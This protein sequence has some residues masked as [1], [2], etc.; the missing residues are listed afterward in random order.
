MGVW[1]AIAK[2]IV[3]IW[4]GLNAIDDL[5]LLFRF[6]RLGSVLVP[7]LSSLQPHMMCDVCDDVMGDLLKGSDGLEALPCGAAC[8]RIPACVRMCENLKNAATNSSHFPCIAAGYCDAVEEGE[9]DA[10]VECRVGAFF[11][12]APRRYCHRSRHGLRFS[13]SLRPGIGRWVGMRNAVASH[14]GALAEGLLS[15][16]RC[17]EPGAG[18]WC[19]ARPRGTGA[20]AEALGHALALLYGG[21]E[22]V[23]SI[24][25]P[26]GDDD[27]QWLIFWLALTLLLFVERFLARVLLSTVPMYYEVK[28]CLLVW[29]ARGGGADT[30]YRRL[31]R[32]LLD[33]LP[34]QLSARVVA[35]EAGEAAK[36]LARLRRDVGGVVGLALAA[37]EKRKA[38]EKAAAEERRRTPSGHVRPPDWEEEEED[39]EDAACAEL[40]AVYEFML[41]EEGTHALAQAP[42]LDSARAVDASERALLIERAAALVSFQPRFVVARLLPVDDSD[43]GTALPPMDPNGLVDAY[44]VLRLEPPGGGGARS[45]YPARGVRSRVAYRTLRPNWGETLELPLRGGHMDDD[46]MYHNQVE[47]KATTLHV[48]VCDADMGAW[49]WLLLLAEFA[50]VALALGALGAHITGALDELTAAHRRLATRATTAIAGVLVVSFV[51]SKRFHADDEVIGEA[52]VP[53]S[54]LLDQRAHT[55]QFTLRTPQFSSVASEVGFSPKAS[56]QAALARLWGHGGDSAPPPAEPTRQRRA[57]LTRST[58]NDKGEVLNSA[59][60][61]KRNEVGGLGVIRM[62]LACSER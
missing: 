34:R 54:T 32:F 60:Q 57:T 39:R 20:V 7:G 5:S 46:G 14:A 55:I 3:V 47:P 19:V 48:E 15:Q 53:V 16:P 43:P 37:H 52:T 13:C 21:F 44:C 12:C 4:A 56:A 49:G 42:A 6:A 27:R 35:D 40:R 11:S 2:P 26:G 31:R 45:R 24:E 30:L 41:T 58:M 1:L 10:D 29:L 8:L 33:A 50:L 25:T 28:L 23:R 9:A 17:G 22:T 51:A 18:P 36:Q 62:E 61:L 59:G 38:A